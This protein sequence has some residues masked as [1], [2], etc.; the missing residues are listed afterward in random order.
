MKK[1]DPAEFLRSV[2]TQ[3]DD[4]PPEFPEEIVNLVNSSRSSRREKI[5][6]LILK[7]T[8]A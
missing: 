8:N 2:L 5:R 1:V 4:M 7:V 6:N 3:V